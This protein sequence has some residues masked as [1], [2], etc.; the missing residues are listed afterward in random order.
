MELKYINI[1]E[2]VIPNAVG[3]NAEP[4]LVLKRT[5]IIFINDLKKK[6]TAKNKKD[7]LK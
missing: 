4:P 7:S 3:E 5:K 2:V 1:K 6:A